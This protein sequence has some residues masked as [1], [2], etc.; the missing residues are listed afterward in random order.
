MMLGDPNKNPRNAKHWTA[1]DAKNAK[2]GTSS[3][4]LASLASLADQL[5]FLI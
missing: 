3:R 1:K 5:A 2:K 4:L